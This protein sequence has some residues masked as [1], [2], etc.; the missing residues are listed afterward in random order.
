VVGAQQVL[1][2]GKRHVKSKV[3]PA[4]PELARRMGIAGKVRIEVIIAPD[5]HVKSARAIGG[6]PLLVAPCLDAAK[7]WKF[8]S[9]PEETTQNVEFIFKD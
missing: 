3:N 1:E 8:D 5:G 2:E 7:E 6:H 4:Y 9:M